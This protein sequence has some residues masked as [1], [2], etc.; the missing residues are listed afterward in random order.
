ML[1]SASAQLAE[2]L[3]ER[4]KLDQEVNNVAQIVVDDIFDEQQDLATLRA[5]VEEAP[6][7]KFVNLIIVQ[8]VHERASD[9]HVEP[10]ERDLRIRYR[11]DG[12]LHERMRQPRSIIPGVVS[13]L[14][15]MADIDIAERR[16]PKDGRISLTVDGSVVDLR[17]STLPTVHGEKIV[18]RILDRASSVQSLVSLGFLPSQLALYEQAFRKP[19]GAILVTA[20]PD[21]AR[22]PRCTRP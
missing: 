10:T 1:R 2:L 15:V 11:I 22:R 7:V 16:V 14:K 12:V 9:I 17:V 6:I 20:R 21:R 8:A 4:R 18:M 13:R 3:D 5:V 19:Y